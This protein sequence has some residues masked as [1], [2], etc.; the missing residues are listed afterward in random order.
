MLKEKILIFGNGQIGNFYNNYFKPKKINSQIVKCDITKLNQVKAVIKKYKP[1]V[2]INTAAKTNLEWCG[3]NKLE[4][5]SVNVLGADN[6]AQICSQE[7]IYF[8]H[9]SSGCIFESRDVKDA[10][11][12]DDVPNPKA[13]YSWT[14][15]WAEQMIEFNK[16]KDFKYIILRPRQPVS[17]QVSH[18]NMLVKFLTF[19]NFIDVPNT[20]T[21]LEDLMDWTWAIIRKK[22]VGILHAANPGFSTPYE[23]A[24]L[25]KKYVLPSL[26][27]KKISKQ[28]LNKLTPNRRVDTILDVSK[29][30][31]LGVKIKPL[32]IRIKEIVKELGQNI[33]TADKKLLK[34]ELEK[35][36]VQ[37]KT[38]TVV[39]DEWRELLK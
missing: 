4:A 19:K 35:T 37:S 1:T 22:P 36:L 32:D 18:K 15:V 23:M 39:N 9:F 28:E 21:V 3:Q 16:S 20:A 2:A 27:I 12:E 25:L 7:K 6:I 11:K 34:A 17:A 5:F 10:K 38:R 31:K 30:E 13:Y 26:P 33:K 14:K 29:L 8:I 24:R